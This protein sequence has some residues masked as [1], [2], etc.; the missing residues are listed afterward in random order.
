MSPLT[1]ARRFVTLALL[2]AAFQFAL[3]AGVP[4]GSLTMGGAFPGRLPASMRLAAMVQALVLVLFGGIVGARA[5]LF[6]PR[7]H[8]GSRKLVWVVVAYTVVGVVLNAIT[9]SAGERAMWL[10]V[11]LVLGACAVVVARAE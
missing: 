8:T 5:R 6:L 2:V 11:T 7:W 3:A 9:P 1:A 4:W 10:P